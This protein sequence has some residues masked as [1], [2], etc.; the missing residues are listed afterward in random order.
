MARSV[1][2]SSGLARSENQSVR[3]QESGPTK[4]RSGPG[5]NRADRA[6]R[7][8]VVTA[9]AVPRRRGHRQPPGEPPCLQACPSL[10]F[11]P[12]RVVLASRRRSP[13]LSCVHRSRSRVLDHGIDPNRCTNSCHGSAFRR[14]DKDKCHGSHFSRASTHVG[15]QSDR[16][17]TLCRDF[18]I[19]GEMLGP[20]FWIVGVMVCCDF[21]VQQIR[22]IQYCFGRL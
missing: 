7:E 3:A 2:A 16:G 14:G 9:A 12:P 17:R 20:D 6:D 8:N 13:S 15:H 1:L 10:P 22:Q 19:V 4:L 5:F 18:W 21:L 11:S